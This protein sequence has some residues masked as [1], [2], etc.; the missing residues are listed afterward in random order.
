MGLSSVA[1]GGRGSGT[2]R[3]AN[4][5]SRVRKADECIRPHEKPSKSHNRHPDPVMSQIKGRNNFDQN[6]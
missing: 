3:K 4:S 2:W 5:N 6:F 1:V